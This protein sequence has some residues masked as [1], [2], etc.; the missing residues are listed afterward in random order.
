MDF[1]KEFDRAEKRPPSDYALIDRMLQGTSRPSISGP[2]PGRLV[3]E[4]P[5]PRHGVFHATVAIEGPAPV[6]FRVGVSDERIYE[7]LASATV[8]V[9]GAWR[10]VRADLSA[11]A[12]WKWSVFY[13]PE[14]V[15]WRLVLS[16][17]AISGVP[18]RVIWGMPE[19]TTDPPAA[20][21]YAARRQKWGHSR[22]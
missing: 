16:A 10:D 1:I 5:L 17:D 15:R 14:R 12:G 22:F 20:R 3:W 19:I 21:E 2:A 9:S 11:Y 7:E 8:D 4:L 6:R 18:G 13:R